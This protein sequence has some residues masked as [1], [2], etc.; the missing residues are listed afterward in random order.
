V[1]R[2][3]KRKARVP[4]VEASVPEAQASVPEAQ[5]SVPEAEVWEPGAEASVPEA[6]VWEPEA[7]ALVPGAQASVPEA[8]AWEPGAEASVPGAQASVPEAEASVPGAP[9]AG[10]PAAQAWVGSAVLEAQAASRVVGNPSDPGPDLLRPAA[11][12][13]PPWGADGV[14]SELA[15]TPHAGNRE[16]TGPPG[17]GRW[18]GRPPLR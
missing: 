9:E 3:R 11:R 17:T 18:D 13:A 14:P 4:E 1:Q 2:G 15:R 8:E 5:A 6:E 12:R 7:Q 10:G 16:R